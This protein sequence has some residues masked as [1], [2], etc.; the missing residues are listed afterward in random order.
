MILLVSVAFGTLFS[1]CNAQSGFII[2]GA[3]DGITNGKAYLISRE[4]ENDGDMLATAAVVGEAFTLTGMVKEVQL[5]TLI[6]VVDGE[7]ARDIYPIF[8]ENATFSVHV[9]KR[10]LTASN[11]QGGGPVQQI[12]SL[13]YNARQ[14]RMQQA[15]ETLTSIAAFKDVISQDSMQHLMAQTT[16]NATIENRIQ[17]DFINAH[18]NSPATAYIVSMQYRLADTAMQKEQLARLGTKAQASKYGKRF[19]DHILRKTREGIALVVGRTAL[20]FTLPT[21]AGDEISLHGIVAKLKLVDFWASWCGP[22]RKENPHVKEI[23]AKYHSKG[24]EIVSV[25]IDTRKEKWLKAIE[26]DGLPWLHVIDQKS[27]AGT[28]YGVMYIPFTVLLDENNT[29]IAT[30]LRGNALE[31]KIVELLD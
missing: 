8:I 7:K 14:E 24:L 27:T 30:N 20:D 10:T 23:Y 13:F 28:L 3:V 21:P 4:E 9:G 11:V 16:A 12:Y 15:A 18:L 31:T 25:S 29:I 1:N 2:N 17:E 19:E 6:V 26:E 5:S 22:C